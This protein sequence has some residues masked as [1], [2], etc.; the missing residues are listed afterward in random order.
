MKTLI[1]PLQV[2]RAAFGATEQVAVECIAEADIAAAERRYIRPVVGAA[3]HEAMLEGQYAEFVR[4]YAATALAV[5]V[6][7][8]VQPRL[9]IKTLSAGSVA[10]KTAVSQPA[11]DVA[12]REQRKALLR[13]ARELM[14]RASEYLNNHAASFSEYDPDNNPLNRCRIHGEFVEI[15]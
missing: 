10:P 2:V 1:T 14:L 7:Y 5:Y 13:E 11:A 6:R 3:M 8:F 4:D 9:D 15:R 12:R